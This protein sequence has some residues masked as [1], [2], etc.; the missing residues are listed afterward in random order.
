[1]KKNLIKKTIMLVASLVMLIAAGI[2]AT[3][4]W[5]TKT[6]N[7]SAVSFDVAKWDFS[8]VFV[9][10]TAELGVHTFSSVTDQKAAPGTN[11]YI[12]IAIDATESDVDLDYV[13]TVDEGTMSQEFQ[14]RLIFFYGEDWDHRTAFEDAQDFD[15]GTAPRGE[16]TVAR[17][18]WHWYYEMVEFDEE[19]TAEEI[20]AWDLF[21]TQVGKNPDEYEDDMKVT[22]RI[23]ATQQDPG[24]HSTS[25]D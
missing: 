6:S 1:L 12:D 3:T 14:D 13:L 2:Y 19:A 16:I 10:D 5:F 4:A 8:A 22:L 20:L 15:S 23:T 17:I 11:G 21:D 24:M 9:T 7:V 25:D 18:Y